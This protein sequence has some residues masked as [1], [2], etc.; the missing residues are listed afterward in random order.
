M[1]YTLMPTAAVAENTKLQLDLDKTRRELRV[2]CI[3][4]VGLAKIIMLHIFLFT[5]SEGSVVNF[6]DDTS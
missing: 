4:L 2:C 3:L 1:L 6:T 5:A